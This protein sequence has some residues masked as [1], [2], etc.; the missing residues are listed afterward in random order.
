MPT[1]NIFQTNILL[2]K[3]IT[4]CH[5]IW[6]YLK[7]KKN[8]LPS[9][10][11]G[12]FIHKLSALKRFSRKA[13]PLFFRNFLKSQRVWVAGV[14]IHFIFV[15]SWFVRRNSKLHM[16]YFQSLKLNEKPITKWHIDSQW[17]QYK[18]VVFFFFI[19]NRK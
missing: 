10:C 3:A 5:C 16:I 19:F 11:Q 7:K 14:K 1:A 4:W 6:F 12:T 9:L 15:D 8:R 13:F 2:F 18:T 17:M